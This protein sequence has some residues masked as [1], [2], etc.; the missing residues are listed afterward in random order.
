M[1]EM[2]SALRN[3]QQQEDNAS[4]TRSRILDTDYAKET[5]TLAANQ[6]V[7]Q[8]STAMLSQANTQIE[9]VLPIINSISE[10]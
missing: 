6:I 7:K 5:A 9:R 1:N 3:T 10:S 2:T 8:A 4:A